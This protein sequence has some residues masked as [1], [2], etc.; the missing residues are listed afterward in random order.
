MEL[1][2]KNMVCD[3][4]IMSVESILSAHLI[5]FEKVD[6]GIVKTILDFD[7]KTLHTLSE[8]FE[9]VGFELIQDK[10]EI[11]VESIKNTLVDLIHNHTDD[12]KKW[13]ISAWIEEHVGRDYKSLSALFSAKEGNTIEHYVIAQKT[14]KAKELLSYKEFTVSE[15]ADKLQYS[16]VAHFSNQ[17]K[18]ETGFSPTEWRNDLLKRIPL[19]HI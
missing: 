2:I 13:N 14:E 1:R 12:L 10:N 9:K 11:W 17:F 6:L 18:K 4:C 16:S 3:R 8:D 5:L 19:D 15:I 7:E